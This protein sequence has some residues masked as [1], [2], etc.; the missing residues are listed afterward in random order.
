[1]YTPIGHA[2]LAHPVLAQPVAAGVTASVGSVELLALDSAL[3][4]C[5]L[6]GHVTPLSCAAH[7]RQMS[8]QFPLDLII[9]SFPGGISKILLLF[10]WYESLEYQNGKIS[11]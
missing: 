7:T 6:N 2:V 11:G 4:V 3:Q 9:S 1:M 5:T 10:G 8:E